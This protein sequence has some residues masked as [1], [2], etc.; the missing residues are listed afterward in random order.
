VD[1]A[2]AAVP[3][4]AIT[5]QN[6]GVVAELCRRL[7]GI[8]LAVELAAARVKALP[9]EKIVERLDD[10][11]HELTTQNPWDVWLMIETGARAPRVDYPPV[12]IFRAS[13]EAFRAGIEEHAI[14]GVAVRVYN[15]A[16]TVA[17]CFRYRNK[18]GLDVALEA[19]RECLR[20]RRATRDDLHR[21]ARIGRVENVMRPYMAALT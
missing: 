9:V 18:I 14:E 10:R 17:D 19:L 20:N 1:R 12:R 15:L 2:A 3:S 16:K 13:G 7:D 4:F 11:F 6:A 8:P 5:A 21:Y